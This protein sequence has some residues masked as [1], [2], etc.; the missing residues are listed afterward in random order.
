MNAS[1]SGESSKNA[2]AEEQ[3]P[4]YGR[5]LYMR[6]AHWF[7]RAAFGAMLLCYLVGVVAVV[8]TFTMH[9]LDWRDAV[10]FLMMVAFPLLVGVGLRTWAIYGSVQGLEI[11]R[12]GTRR[13]VP[14]A[15]VGA[16]EYAW[17]SQNRAARFA[18]L[19]LCE[20]R[21]RTILFFAN[22]RN[23]AELH[24]MRALYAGR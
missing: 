13:T 24:A 7:A 14:W 20:E 5:P 11:V 15:S 10:G 21:E 3:A 8:S 9:P 23:L 1:T 6:G 16:A 19:T 18:R 12:W 22:D 2:G 4:P 17:W